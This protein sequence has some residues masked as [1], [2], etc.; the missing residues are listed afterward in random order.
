MAED[1]KD[2]QTGLSRFIVPMVNQTPFVGIA[3]R[4]PMGMLIYPSGRGVANVAGSEALNHLAIDAHL[5]VERFAVKFGCHEETNQVACFVVDPLTPGA[6][7]V[8]RDKGHPTITLYMHNLFKDMPKLRPTSKRWC[9]LSVERD[10]TTGAAIILLGVA[11]ARRTI[12]RGTPS[13]PAS[14]TPQPQTP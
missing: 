6:V 2:P 4:D 5:D 11:L 10:G 3:N 13:G 9:T 1:P 14:A 12:S 7:A 8:R